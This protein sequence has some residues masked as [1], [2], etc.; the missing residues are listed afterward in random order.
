MK[1][2]ILLYGSQQ[3]YDAM[4]GRPSDKPTWMPDDFAVMGAFMEAFNRGLVESG[5]LVGTRGLLSGR[6]TPGCELP[7]TTVEDGSS[8]PFGPR[9]QPRA[10]LIPHGFERILTRPV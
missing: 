1:Y 10:H 5:E 2:M 6:S 8:V 4:S 9:C 7:I 3:D